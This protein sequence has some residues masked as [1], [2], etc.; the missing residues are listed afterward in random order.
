MIEALLSAVESLGGVGR[1]RALLG[2]RV[3]VTLLVA[4]LMPLELGHCALMPMQASAVAIEPDHADG[5][6]HDCCPESA[7]SQ[8]PTSP[9]NSS[10]SCWARS[11]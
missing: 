9:T 2:L 3:I 4:V 11:C 8:V 10:S 6:D 7:P 1:M 5:D